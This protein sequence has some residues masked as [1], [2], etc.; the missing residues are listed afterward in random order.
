MSKPNN[1]NNKKDKSIANN[2]GTNSSNSNTSTPIKKQSFSERF[3][4]FKANTPS[5]NGRETKVSITKVLDED[6]NMIGFTVYNFFGARD[7]FLN[8]ISSAFLLA[9]K[10]RLDAYVKSGKIISMNDIQYIAK[11][12][13]NPTVLVSSYPPVE[14][15]NAKETINT[16]LEAFITYFTDNNDPV[17][18]CKV[19]FSFDE[20]FQIKSEDE[21]NG[22]FFLATLINLPDRLK[23]NN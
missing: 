4:E 8:E 3:N 17:N 10:D 14:N 21:I 9:Y 19:K 23:A 11:D 6:N 12:N 7:Y 2:N 5:T 13:N 20:D 16:T 18:N 1:N 22:F 15:T